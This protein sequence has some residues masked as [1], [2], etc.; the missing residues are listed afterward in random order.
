MLGHADAQ[1]PAAA[2]SL[3]GLLRIAAEAAGRRLQA[4]A[5]SI[6]AWE[7][8]RGTL[9][10]LFVDSG[11]YPVANPR[12]QTAARYLVAEWPPVERLLRDARP[13]VLA[14]GEPDGDPA[15]L[16]WL[17]QVGQDSC[18]GVPILLNG[19]VWGQLMVTRGPQQLPFGAGDLAE[20]ER[21]SEEVAGAIAPVLHL[22]ALS[23]LAYSDTLTDLENGRAVEEL[24]A[25]AIERY[26]AEGTDVS[27][28]LLD[29]D[30]MAEIN[31][32]RGRQAGDAVL[33]QVAGLVSTTAAGAAP[34]SVAG[35]LGGDRFCVLME[36]YTADDAERLAG[37][38][39]A[40]AAGT[41][42][43]RL[44][45]GVASTGEGVGM[46]ASGDRLLEVA[47]VALG[48]AR[49]LDTARP[50]VAGRELPT[51]AE[52]APALRTA[53]SRTRR[54]PGR[55]PDRV[56]RDGLA[57]LDAA[58]PQP[59]PRM[60]AVADRVCQ[61][62]D[63]CAWWVSRTDQAGQNLEAAAWSAT[64][65]AAGPVS[66]QMDVDSTFPLADY[67]QTVRMLAGAG[68]LV[69][70]D[71]PQADAAET[72]L[73]VTAGYAGM[74]MAGGSEAGGPGWLVEVFLDA[75][76]ADASQVPPVLRAL[77]GCALLP[78]PGR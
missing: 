21:V 12:A 9:R 52:A 28:V 35:R 34:G 38:L 74:L 75:L 20:A 29:V 56:L 43:V 44:A 4:G 60:S 22:G 32:A 62:V 5:V 46:V 41:L 3:D 18:L 30:G 68:T 51:P 70:A 23:R 31:E 6:S 8:S 2:G 72:A 59:L 36:G 53:G 50:V 49:R 40:E 47:A 19:S 65:F 63:G 76:S 45:S 66:A 26:R 15:M 37:D 11:G 7:R 54:R 24:L 1:H 78:A 73:L 10:P 39:T 58:A 42:G 27:L 61:L 13:F 17:E 55:R 64:R 16:A 25:A 71:D 48:T 14:A 57:A 33:R 67:P 77:V 69:M